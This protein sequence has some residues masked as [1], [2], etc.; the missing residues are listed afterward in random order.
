MYYKVNFIQRGFDVNPDLNVYNGQG[1][2][3]LFKA[4]RLCSTFLLMYALMWVV[5]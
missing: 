3:F 1:E 5:H 2:G 4:K